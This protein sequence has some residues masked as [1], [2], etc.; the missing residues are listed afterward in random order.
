MAPPRLNCVTVRPSPSGSL[1]LPST[2]PVA[3]VSSAVVAL[4]LT[5]TGAWLVG[6]G[7]VVSTRFSDTVA[8]L[9][10]EPWLSVTKNVIAAWPT[11]SAAGWNSSP[12]ACAGVSVCPA[13]TTVVP[14]AS[15]SV[16]PVGMLVT[17]TLA[18]LPS[19]ST[20]RS[21][22]GSVAF[23]GPLT[24]PSSADGAMLASAAA[25]PAVSATGGVLLVPSAELGSS[26]SVVRASEI[27]STRR[28]GRNSPPSPPARPAAVAASASFCA[29]LSMT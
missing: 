13:L 10:V 29:R 8:L 21:A 6:G 24:V 20:P 26:P 9:D 17:V 22:I 27:R 12:A 11:N 7:G 15:S 3:G 19:L 4:S 1:S 5:P 2:L 23:S 18:T 25:D 28:P 14:S 16:P